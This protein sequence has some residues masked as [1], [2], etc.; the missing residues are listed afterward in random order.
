M[1]KTL[2]VLMLAIGIVACKSGEVKTVK[3]DKVETLRE[4]KDEKVLITPK[5]KIAIASF[6]NNIAIAEKRKAGENLSDEEFRWLIRILQ[7]S[8]K[9]GT[10]ISQRKKR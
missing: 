5:R 6:K 1:K 8:K 3:D 2:I 9:T 7:K 4:Y 10:P